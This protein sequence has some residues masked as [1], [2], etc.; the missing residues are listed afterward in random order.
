MSSPNPVADAVGDPAGAQQAGTGRRQLQG[1]RQAVER[2]AQA[3]DVVHAARDPARAGGQR[4][5]HEEQHGLGVRVVVVGQFE[6]RHP[7]HQL[8]GDAQGFAAGDQ[9]RRLGALGDQLGH[10]LGAPLDQ[11]LAVVEDDQRPGRA[12]AHPQAVEQP[13]RRLVAH[14]EHLGQLVDDERRP[15]DAGQLDQPHAP[16]EPGH[17]PRG[18]A[19]RQAGLADAADATERDHAFLVDQR[20]QLGHVSRAPDEAVGLR[21]KVVRDLRRHV[22]AHGGRGNCP[23]RSVSTASALDAITLRAEITTDRIGR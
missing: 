21:G 12:Q 14:A 18:D 15:A 10:Q 6:R 8:A 5:L 2:A 16:R 23:S 4:P 1:Q 20:A 13:P 22:R 17:R 19:Q 3:Y 11:V 9:E 7:P